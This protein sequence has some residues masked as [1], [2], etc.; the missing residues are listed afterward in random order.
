M[1]N[2]EELGRHLDLRNSEVVVETCLSAPADVHGAGDVGLGP[3]HH[4]TEFIPVFHFLK[5][6]KFHGS[7]GDDH[8]VVVVF[9][10]VVK[11]IV[12]GDEMLHGSV[13]WMMGSRD[14]QIQLHL[15]GCVSDKTCDLGLSLYFFGHQIEQKY[16][17]RTD[18]LSSSSGFRHYEDIFAFEYL[19]CG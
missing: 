17:K 6:Q 16:F 15:N 10:D 14:Q 9:F 13:L 18:L 1:E 8:A 2:S 12:E 11:G 4:L 19:C 3:F 7:S 5:V